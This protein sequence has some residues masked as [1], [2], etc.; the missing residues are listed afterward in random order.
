LKRRIE[1]HKL[2]KVKSTRN[3]LPVKL[4]CYEAYFTKKETLLREK[5]LKSS[6][7]KKDIRRRLKYSLEKIAGP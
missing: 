5:Y 2:G 7:G 1:E 6:D 3:R 4:L